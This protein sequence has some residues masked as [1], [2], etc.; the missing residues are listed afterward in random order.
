M[1]DNLENLQILIIDE[2]SMMKSDMLYQLDLRLRELKGRPNNVFGG[3]ATFMFDDILQLR[4]VRARFIFEEPSNPQFKLTD[5]LLPL[6]D[7]F[8]I[9]K[10]TDNH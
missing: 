3:V 1:K 5:A 9:I 7:L 6:W 2:F 10:L 8:K 4:P